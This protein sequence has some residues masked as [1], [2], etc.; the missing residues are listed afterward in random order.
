MV[1]LKGH[2]IEVAMKVT[3]EGPFPK[4]RERAA[5]GELFDRQEAASFLG[6]SPRTLDR[7]HLLRE[8]PARI[9]LGRK[10]RYRRT[11]LE[12][13]LLSRETIGPRCA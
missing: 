10:I 11:S 5:L 12:D 13:W 4:A 2:W 3:A 9:E 1:P 7:W 6:V 8:G